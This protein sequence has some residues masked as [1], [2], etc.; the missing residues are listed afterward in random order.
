MSH[1][2]PRTNQC[3]LKVQKIIHLQNLA[4]QLLDTFIDYC[5]SVGINIEHHVAHTHTQN[6][7]AKSFIKRLQLIARP[8]LM[9]TKLCISA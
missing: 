5:M 1:L 4:N 3:E 6:G 2:D 7:S 9:K 8:L